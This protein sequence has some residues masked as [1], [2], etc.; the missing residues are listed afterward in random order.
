[1]PT[2][3][4]ADPHIHVAADLG[5]DAATRGLI[6][7]TFNRAADLPSVVATGCGT[8][9]QRAM[10][11]VRPESVTCLPCREHAREHHLRAA[12]QI[13][14]LGRT[15]GSAVEGEPARKAADW[16]RDLARRF[17]AR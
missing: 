6:A 8:Q 17:A 3:K 2:E 15:P 11:S 4:P 1:M 12:E 7:S 10:T 5:A 14:R 13:E 9:A 16:H